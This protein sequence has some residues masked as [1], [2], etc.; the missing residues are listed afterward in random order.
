MYSKFVVPKMNARIRGGH[1]DSKIG[2]SPLQLSN[3][4]K[5]LIDAGSVKFKTHLT[6]SD[7]AA[8]LNYTLTMSL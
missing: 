4:S 6:L 8:R 3:L 1:N 2:L 7:I 5:R